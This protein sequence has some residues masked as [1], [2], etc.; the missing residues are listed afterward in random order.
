MAIPVLVL[1]GL[2]TLGTPARAAAAPSTAA[3]ARRVT[4]CAM[5]SKQTL[6]NSQIDLEVNLRL[7]IW[8]L[9]PFLVPCCKNRLVPKAS[10][11]L[12]LSNPSE[13]LSR[14]MTLP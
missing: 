4:K 6:R 5:G 10:H 11:Y 8:A 7:T 2:A 9:A 14:V 12:R 3:R 13:I 1:P